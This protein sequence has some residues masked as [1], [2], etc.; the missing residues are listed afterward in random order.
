MLRCTRIAAWGFGAGLHSD[1]SVLGM[2][3]VKYFAYQ[4]K[5]EVRLPWASVV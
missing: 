3:V 2:L 4:H 5:A 1:P